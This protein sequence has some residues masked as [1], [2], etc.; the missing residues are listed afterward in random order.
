MEEQ[1]EPVIKKHLTLE[2]THVIMKYPFYWRGT[3]TEAAQRGESI[4]ETYEEL[5]SFEEML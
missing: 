1:E 4:K 5:K 3:L 2:Q